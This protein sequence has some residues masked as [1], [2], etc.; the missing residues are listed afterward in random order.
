LYGKTLVRVHA[1]NEVWCI[2]YKGQFKRGNGRYCYPLKVT[3]EYS[4]YILV[5]ERF[6]SISG[7]DVE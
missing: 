1:C 4:R 6:E 3:D 7:A 2:D 5:C